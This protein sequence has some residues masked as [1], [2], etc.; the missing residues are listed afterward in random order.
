MIQTIAIITLKPGMRDAF[1]A[2]FRDNLA[3]VRAE[4]GCIEYGPYVDEVIDHPIQQALGPDT[5]VVLERWADAA[6]LKA[7][8]VAPHMAPFGAKVRDLVLGRAIHVLTPA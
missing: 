3:N 8:I 6:A 5:V 2:A 1:L 4:Q 7:H